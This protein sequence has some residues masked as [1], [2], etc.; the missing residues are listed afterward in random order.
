MSGWPAAVRLQTRKILDGI[1]PFPT[2]DIL[3]MKN[4]GN[5]SGYLKKAD[6]LNGQIILYDTASQL[7]T[8]FQSAGE[9]FDAGWVAD[10]QP[11]SQIHQSTNTEVTTEQRNQAAAVKNLATHTL[12]PEA[13]RVVPLSPCRVKGRV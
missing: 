5:F 12:N 9:M 1:V 13:N 7:K 11:T 4:I 10:L 6:R 8:C 2:G 3:P